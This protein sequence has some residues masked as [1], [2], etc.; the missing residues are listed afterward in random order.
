[1]SKDDISIVLNGTKID[2]CCVQGEVT[3]VADLPNQL[4]KLILQNHSSKKIRIND[5]VVQGSRA[6]KLLYLSYLIDAAGKLWQ[7]ATELWQP[8]QT[9]ILPFMT[10]V[11]AW[12]TEVES[13]IPNGLLGKNLFESHA[14]YF[15]DSIDISNHDVPVVVQDFFSHDF[16][17]TM[18]DRKDKLKAP[19][20]NCNKPIDQFLLV[21]AAEEIVQ[22]SEEFYNRSTMDYS[23][24]PR[25]NMREFSV[26]PHDVWKIFPVR[27]KNQQWPL[28]FNPEL[29]RFPKLRNFVESL[30][31]PSVSVFVGVLPPGAFIVPHIDDKSHIPDDL[32]GCTQLYIPLYCTQG[33]WLKFANAG[34]LSLEA[35]KPLVLNTYTYTHCAVN[36]SDKVRYVLGLYA[37]DLSILDHCEWPDMYL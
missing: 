29:E 20:L 27:R 11:S 1:M 14:F 5:V 35:G 18:I 3:I 23:Y 36:L 7:P 8:G 26:A 31:T 21:E 6:R 34:S 37:C 30:Q 17:F 12:I 32:K 28:D 16:G 24:Q 19:Y 2:H 9:W 25:E 10:P 22:N 15:P 33:N 13:K 4:H